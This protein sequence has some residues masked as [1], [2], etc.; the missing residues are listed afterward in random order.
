M[1]SPLRKAI[2]TG[3]SNRANSVNLTCGAVSPPE[4]PEVSPPE[5]PE[6]SPPEPP[7][8][9]TAGGETG[10]ADAVGVPEEQATSAVLKRARPNPVR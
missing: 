1:R 9:V 5:P 10:E 7:E 8:D 6:V 4:P 2:A 3:F